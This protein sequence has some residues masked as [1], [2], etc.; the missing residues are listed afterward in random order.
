ME[1]LSEYQ[2]LPSFLLDAVNETSLAANGIQRSGCIGDVTA[3]DCNQDSACTSDGGCSLDNPCS[4]C[5]DKPCSDCSDIP[6]RLPA[7]SITSVFATDTTITIHMAS[8][9]GA[10]KYQVAIR[11]ESVTGN[12]VVYTTTSTSYT[13]R[14]LDPDTTY[15]VNYRG[16]DSSGRVGDYM[17][18]GKTVTTKPAFTKFDWTF[19]GVTANGVPVSGS[20]KTSGLGIY[21]TADEWNELAGLIKDVTGNGVTTVSSGD[22]ITAAIVN[23]AAKALGVATVTKNVTEISAA[24][25]NGLRTAYNN[26]A[27][28]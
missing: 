13:F 26:L 21:V 20:T 9:S 1:Y 14:N 4:D 28:T 18:S 3:E 11:L 8:I 6:T 5:S 19:A 16:V 27:S 15:V 7:G 10:V 24:F 23:T 2:P 22:T 25:F 12:A 17:S